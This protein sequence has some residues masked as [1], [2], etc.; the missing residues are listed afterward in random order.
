[1]GNV[2]VDMSMS[3]DGFIAGPKDEIEPLHDW[4]AD[5][6]A[7][8]GQ[9]LLEDAFG[10][11]GAVIMGRRT[12]DMV[13]APDGWT[14][15]DGTQFEIDVFVLTSRPRPPVTK[16]KTSFTFVSDGIESALVQARA[17]AGG[18]DV[19]VM[20]AQSARQC[21][22]AG[23]L[24]ELVIHLVPVVLGEGIALFGDGGRATFE[25]TALLEDPT[26]THLCFRAVKAE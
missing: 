7:V 18:K 22:A 14:F 17:V 26:V 8:K 21:L 24:D 5:P 10:R 19:S 6:S 9:A 3:L 20:G 2:V 25:R 12:F 13:D 1:M 4:L 16:G 15:P 11:A 23:F